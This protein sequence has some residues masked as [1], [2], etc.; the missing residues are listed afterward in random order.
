MGPG[1]RGTV[2]SRH[3]SSLGNHATPSRPRT[4]LS[5]ANAVRTGRHTSGGEVIGHT[6]TYTQRHIDE[7][8]QPTIHQVHRQIA[9]R[10]GCHNYGG[11]K[12]SQISCNF[13]RPRNAH[14]ENYSQLANNVKHLETRQ[15][16]H[17]CSNAPIFT[18][19]NIHQHTRRKVGCYNCGEFNHIQAIRRY[20]HKLRCETCHALGHKS[21]L[22]YHY[23]G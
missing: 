20:D 7:H 2:P 23:S 10:H 19:S 18:S 9:P 3:P 8:S 12:H 13:V 1:P 14:I 4:D 11:I 22:C 5:L 21:R 16:R 15:P 17:Y 6:A